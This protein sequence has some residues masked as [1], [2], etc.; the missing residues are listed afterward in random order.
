MNVSIK[1]IQF[2]DLKEE[3]QIKIDG[4]NSV[5]DMITEVNKI[6]SKIGNCV[7]FM[8]RGKKLLPEKSLND[9]GIKEGTKLMMY[10][11]TESSTQNEP[12]ISNK[13]IAIQKLKEKGY[14]E[15]MIL[16]I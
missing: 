3:I 9:Q 7:Q 12:K 5:N 8:F 14:K 16:P 11:S 4:T 2:S 10:K 13:T 15:D 1:P 6:N